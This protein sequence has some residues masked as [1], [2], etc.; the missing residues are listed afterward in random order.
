M[1]ITADARRSLE[2]YN[3][4]IGPPGKVHR[5]WDSAR[6]AWRDSVAEGVEREQ[7][8]PLRDDARRFST[9]LERLLDQLDALAP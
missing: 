3:G 1:R 7:Y 4:W 6:V 2:R 8:G 5:D 9:D